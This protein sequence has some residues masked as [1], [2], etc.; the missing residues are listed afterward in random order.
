M[1]SHT[2]TLSCSIEGCDR[3]ILGRGWCQRHYAQWRRT[4]NPLPTKRLRSETIEGRIWPHVIV[5]PIPEHREDLGPCWIWTGSISRLGY[6]RFKWRGHFHPTHRWTYERARGPVPVGKELDHLCRVRHCCNP[7]HLEAVTHRQ[8]M[9]RSSNYK[10]GRRV[11][12]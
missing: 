5:G 2:S 12:K 6:G 9:V 11:R 10:H 7:D 1:R 4:G 3:P 8:N